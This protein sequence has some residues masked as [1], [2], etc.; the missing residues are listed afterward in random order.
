MRTVHIEPLTHENFVP[1]GQFYP[2]EQPQG[3]RQ[4]QYWKRSQPESADT[5]SLKM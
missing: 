3:L 1:F 5:S 2:M 4:K